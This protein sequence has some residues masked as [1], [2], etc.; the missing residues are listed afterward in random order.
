MDGR[1]NP[2]P[3]TS[4]EAGIGDRGW[5]KQWN[6]HLAGIYAMQHLSVQV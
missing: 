4:L 5:V 6:R 1:M 3:K 2:H